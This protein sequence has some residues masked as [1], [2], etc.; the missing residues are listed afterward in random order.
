MK[1]SCEVK[2]RGAWHKTRHKTRHLEN[3]LL[4]VS[5]ARQDCIVVS[6]ILL[7]FQMPLGTHLAHAARKDFSLYAHVSHK[8]SYHP[9]SWLPTHP[10]NLPNSHDE[11][12]PVHTVSAKRYPVLT[13]MAN[14]SPKTECIR[15]QGGRI[16]RITGNITEPGVQSCRT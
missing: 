16:Y 15:K 10:R 8:S 4:M 1:A 5:Y 7:F 2:L 13:D 9:P 6:V 14:I 3:Y 12:S 11:R